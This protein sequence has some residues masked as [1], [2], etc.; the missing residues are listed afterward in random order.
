MRFAKILLIIGAIAAAFIVG[1][2]QS[3]KRA[4]SEH[5]RKILYW[6]DPMHPAYKSDKPGI[7]PDCGMRLVPVYAGTAGPPVPAP[8][9]RMPPGTVQIDAQ[10]Q[11]L[12]GVRYGTVEYESGTE[13]IRAVGKIAIDET[14]VSHVHSR[15]EGWVEKVYANFVG[16]TVKKGQPMLTIYSPELLATEQEYLLALKARDTMALAIFTGMGGR[17]SGM[18]EAAEDSS[19]LVDASRRRLQL[20]DLSDSQI[21]EVERTRKPLSSVTLYAPASGYVTARNAFANQKVMPETEIYTITDLSRIWVFASVFEYQMPEVHVDQIA[22]V[23]LPYDGG[24]SLRAR[25]SYIQ[26]Q[27]DPATRTIQVRLDLPNPGTALKPEMFVN[28]EL[29]SPRAERLMVPAEAVLDTGSRKVVFVDRGN[30]YFEPRDVTAGERLGDRIQILSGLSAGE[31]IVTSGNFLIN[32]ESQLQ[33]AAQGM[34]GMPG[35]AAPPKP[36]AGPAGKQE[37]MPGMPGMAPPGGGRHD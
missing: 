30:G 3:S 12:I 37:S 36:Q 13:T 7:A 20:W 9:A 6:V 27:V 24:R 32:S 11:Q 2:W 35:M 17:H 31:R 25:V 16:D 22:T 14:R 5:D 19:S 23:S 10:R 21:D 33:S 26:P 1:R 18:H 15:T 29:K 8:G 28:V 34:A 4:P